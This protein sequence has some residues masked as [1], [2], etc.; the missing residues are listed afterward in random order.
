M[1]GANLDRIQVIKGWL[2]ENGVP[3]EKVFDV[4]WS[5][6]RTLSANGKLS[7]VGNTVDA[8]TATYTNTIGEITLQTTWK[9]PEFDAAKSAFYYLLH[10]TDIIYVQMII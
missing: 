9:D 3:Q 5:G 6:N 1:E 2:D 10:C 4:V 7:A 8:K